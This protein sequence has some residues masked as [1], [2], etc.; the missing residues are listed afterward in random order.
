MS[1]IHAIKII[2]PVSVEPPEGF[3]QALD[4]LIGMICKKYQ[5]E[6]PDR[7]MWPASSGSKPLFNPYTVGD[8]DP[9]PF[10]DSIYQIECSEREDYWGNN[11][12]NPKAAELQ[13]QASFSSSPFG[14]TTRATRAE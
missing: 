3:C 6:N 9:L 1:K 4:G 2:F 8:D 7:V 12:H 11:P 10:D 5:A 14:S 13:K